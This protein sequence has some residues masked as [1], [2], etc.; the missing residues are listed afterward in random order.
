MISRKKNKVRFA[1]LLSFIVLLWS[2]REILVISTG[3]GNR[4]LE[5]V[6]T[7]CMTVVLT[8]IIWFLIIEESANTSN[9]IL[10]GYYIKLLMVQTVAFLPFYTQNFMYGDDIWG[11]AKD[12]NGDI[13]EGLYF[14]RPFIKFLLGPLSD[15]SFASMNVFRIFNGFILFLFGCVLLRFMIEQGVK[16]NKAFC[17]S[18]IAISGCVAVD[19]IAYASVYP[20]NSSL[21]FSAVSY[22]M[23]LKAREEAKEKKKIF[24]LISGICLFS[25]FCMY[26]IGTPVVFLM[27]MITERESSNKTEKNRFGNA[28]IFMINYGIVAICYLMVTKLFQY[29]TGVSAGQAARAEF[30]SSLDDIIKKAE[31]FVTSVIPQSLSRISAIFFG[32]TLFNENNMFYTCTYKNA[33]LG[34]CMVVGLLILI[35]ISV[36]VTS[37]KKKSMVYMFLSLAAIPLSFWP[38]LILPENTYLTYYA[39]GIVILLIWYVW[40]GASILF[41]W[42]KQKC[43][44]IGRC[45]ERMKGI[46]ISLLLITV[47]L[48][49]N[50]YGENSW[51]NYSRDSYEYLANTIASKLKPGTDTIAV[52][53]SLSPYVGGREYVIFCVGDILTELGCDAN[54]FEIIQ[55]DNEYYVSIFND[56]E[57]K[58]MEQKLGAE[59]MDRLYQYYIHD[60]LY[61]R[62]CF[63]GTANDKESLE[64][65][66]ECFF[67][68]GQLKLAD[69]NTIFISMDGFNI[70][71]PF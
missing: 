20:I 55:S 65:L 9:K 33:V 38:F 71:N 23:Y 62:W 4:I 40:D 12:F 22:I 47:A 37:Y 21:L 6:F 18:A 15:T 59:R 28:F 3:I 41:A 60:D 42:G 34:I 2:Q 35:L 11:F 64:F 16:F 32:N 46:I 49:S 10:G 67:N 56:S 29:I 19:C 24:F 5:L 51:V 53:G 54:S 52:T 63:N 13:S 69:E 39:L 27:Y 17:F 8:A 66:Q 70:R 58:H 44:F 36:I 48:Q 14:S 30:I 45:E 7:I 25:A 57:V 31:W 50:N 1:M 68:T 26:Q 61:S 43:K